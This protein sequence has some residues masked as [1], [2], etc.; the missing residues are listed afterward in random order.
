MATAGNHLLPDSFL[1]MID[2]LFQRMSFNSNVERSLRQLVEGRH[3]ERV[4]DTQLDSEDIFHLVLRVLW[5][6]VTQPVI[7]SLNLEV[8]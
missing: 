2:D 5:I 8:Y 4:S 7:E 3:M 6:S 1:P